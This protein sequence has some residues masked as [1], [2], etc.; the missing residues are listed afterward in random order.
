MRQLRPKAVISYAYTNIQRLLSKKVPYSLL[1]ALPNLYFFRN[2]TVLYT[3]V[4]K[5]VLSLN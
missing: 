5:Q 4:I 1:L 3:L 2:S